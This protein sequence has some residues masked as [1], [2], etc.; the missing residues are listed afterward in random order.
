MVVFALCIKYFAEK[1]ALNKISHDHIRAHIIAVFPHHVLSLGTFA[2]S[3]ELAAFVDRNGGGHFA[4]NINV[5]FQSQKR[6]GYV[7]R[8]GSADDYR[9]Q[10][11]L[12]QHFFIIGIPFHV[13]KVVHGL[14]HSVRIAVADCGQP[15]AA[16]FGKRVQKRLRPSADSDDTEIKQLI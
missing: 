2:C 11:L 14:C 13:G 4:E 1:S 12:L 3:D 16:R 5:F 9:I 7:Q 6:L 8:H 10:I 15:R